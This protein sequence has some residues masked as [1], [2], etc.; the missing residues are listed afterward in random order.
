[1]RATMYVTV[2]I[3]STKHYTSRDDLYTRLVGYDGCNCCGIDKR[4]AI[5]TAW[6]Q[7]WDVMDVIRELHIDWNEA[8]ALEFLGPPGFNVQYQ[9]VIQ[10][11]INNLG[12]MN[13]HWV[14]LPLDWSINVRCDDWDRGC[15]SSH[16]TVAYTVNNGPRGIATINFCDDFFNEPDLFDQLLRGQQSPDYKWKYDMRNYEDSKAVTFLHELLHINWV[17]RGGPYG[18]NQAVV[19][20]EVEFYDEA[21][22]RYRVKDVYGSLYSKILARWYESRTNP[23]IGGIIARSA[24]NLALY[25]LAKYLIVHLGAYPHYPL[26]NTQPTSRPRVP[27]FA[28]PFIVEDNGTVFLNSTYQ[29]K[30]GPGLVNAT[31]IQIDQFTPDSDYPSSYLTDWNYWANPE[32]QLS[33]LHIQNYDGW[34]TVST[35][36]QSTQTTQNVQVKVGDSVGIWD[37]WVTYWSSHCPDQTATF[38]W[39][40]DYGD[41][42]LQKDGYMHDSTGNKIGDIHITNCS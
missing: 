17:Y 38:M 36:S 29:D 22:R 25:S 21:A 27:Y 35:M 3:C 37:G 26:V 13:G 40:A 10:Q 32:T 30:A 42:Y 20:F 8:A 18:Q 4:Q 15:S 14:E 23:R 19:D 41:V 9:A 2:F 1:M 11:I 12:T 39:P 16:P 5:K 31:T 34:I 24:E 33:N 6:Q 28:Q 7:S